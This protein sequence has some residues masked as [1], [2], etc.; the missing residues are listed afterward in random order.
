MEAIGA[1]VAFCGAIFVPLTRRDRRPPV[2]VA[3]PSRRDLIGIVVDCCVISSL[4]KTKL[5]AHESLRIHVPVVRL[6]LSLRCHLWRLYWG[7]TFDRNMSRLV[8]LDGPTWMPDRLPL[9]IAR[10]CGATLVLWATYEPC[11]FSTIW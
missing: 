1:L 9:E 3:K 2:R 5:I 6:D 7:V 8:Y 4:P 11:S 10:S